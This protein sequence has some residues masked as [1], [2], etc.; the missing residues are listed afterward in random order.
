MQK[1]QYVNSLLADKT[2]PNAS[3]FADIVRGF[4]NS[5]SQSLA[6]KFLNKMAADKAIKNA[7]EPRVTL[8]SAEINPYLYSDNS[9]I[10][11]SV[12]DASFAAFGNTKDLPDANS[13]P[14]VT[15][16]RF[17][18]TT[19]NHLDNA[20]T[21]TAVVRRNTSHEWTM[22]YFRTDPTVITV[23]KEKEVAYAVRQ[24]ELQSH[25]SELNQAVTNSTAVSWAQGAVGVAETVD[26]TTGNDFFQLTSGTARANSVVGA[27]GN[28]KKIT[29][30]DMKRLKSALF[31][32]QVVN[33]FGTMYFLPTVEQYDDLLDEDDFNRFDAS[34]NVSARI[35][36]VVGMM[37][38]ITILDPR[39]RPDWGANILYSY[40][41]PVGNDQDFTLVDDTASSGA[42]M[43][44]AGIAW[45]D[46][47]VLRAEGLA[48]VFPSVS[49]PTYMGDVYASELRYSSIKKR[50]DGKGTI[51]L[52]ENPN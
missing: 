31:R 3:V 20:P 2:N 29:G 28:V 36:G 21:T 22:Q 10:K 12:N 34:G 47:L 40:D 24:E 52:L 32:Q 11:K 8:Y 39:H 50:G 9:F 45:V 48:M 1:S 4:E 14:A 25:A 5:A 44:S 30:D 18:P 46:R 49:D 23:E 27:S 51:M 35:D 33:G 41:A 13:G 7:T 16:G 43:V 15:K 19:L 17:Q 38:G 26:I 42:N 6:K 37:Y